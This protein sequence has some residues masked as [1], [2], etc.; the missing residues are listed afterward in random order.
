MPF[1]AF[2]EEKQFNNRFVVVT[3]FVKYY[4][5]VGFEQG[6]CAHVVYSFNFLACHFIFEV[7]CFHCYTANTNEKPRSKVLVC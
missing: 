1:I 4:V 2:Y 3:I 5:L 6:S 7:I